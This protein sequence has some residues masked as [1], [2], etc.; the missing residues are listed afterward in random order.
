MHTTK[1]KGCG[2]T[3][4]EM[5]GK[6]NHYNIAEVAKKGQDLVDFGVEPEPDE[7]RNRSDFNNKSIDGSKF[8]KKQRPD[9]DLKMFENRVEAS[10]DASLIMKLNKSSIINALKRSYLVSNSLTSRT[11]FNVEISTVQSFT[12]SDFAKN[13]HLVLCKH[14]LF[15][16]LH[17]LIGKDLET[18]LQIRFIEENDL[19]S[20]FDAAG[21][22]VRHQFLLY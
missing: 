5:S 10:Y 1:G 14:I 15:I 20:L 22:D 21:K 7:M 3:L 19:R 8:C 16:V 18:S 6:Q 2:P 4:T 9:H 11:T 13:G 17:V 12:R